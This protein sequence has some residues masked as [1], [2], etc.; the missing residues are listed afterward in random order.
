MLGESQP[1]ITESEA[2]IC[3]QAPPDQICE[4]VYDPSA[5]ATNG[6][7]PDDAELCTP[8]GPRR[9]AADKAEAKK[10]GGQARGGGGGGNSGS[11][12]GGDGDIPDL[13]GDLPGNL[14]T[15]GGGSGGG[16]GLD[17]ILDGLPG[18]GN[19]G[20][21]NGGGGGGGGGAGQAA[22]DLLDFLFTP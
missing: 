10:R 13:P 12:D 2:S 4:T 17:D 21:N 22:N 20:K 16:G 5:C 15:P 11:P 14:P 1:E 19:G 3:A 9:D 18:P 8:P 7:S 6:V